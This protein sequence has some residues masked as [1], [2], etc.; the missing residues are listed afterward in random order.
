M[1]FQTIKPL[2]NESIIEM[3]SAIFLLALIFMLI[4]IKIAAQTGWCGITPPTHS[5]YMASIQ[6]QSVASTISVSR[7]LAIHFYVVRNSL[8]TLPGN[9]SAPS[10]Q[11]TLITFIRNSIEIANVLFQPKMISFYPSAITFINSDNWFS[12]DLSE[13]S[14]I[15]SSYNDPNAINVYLVQDFIPRS[16]NLAGY[17]QFPDANPSNALFL[18]VS[19]AGKYTM[20]H[21]LGHYFNILHTFN[22]TWFDRPVEYPAAY[23]GNCSTSG[24]MICDTPVEPTCGGTAWSCSNSDICTSNPV[25]VTYQGNIYTFTPIRGNV[26]SY[27]NCSTQSFTSQQL[28]RIENTLL[29]HPNR[30]FLVDNNNPPAIKLTSM[31]AYTIRTNEINQSVSYLKQ[32]PLKLFRDNILINTVYS[33]ATGGIDV[34]AGNFIPG[35]QLGKI[36]PEPN[37][38]LNGNGAINS[39]DL[40]ILQNH[41]TNNV[42]ITTPYRL[43]AA[44][45]NN[46]G[47]VSTF[48]AIFLQ[49]IILGIYTTSL[50]NNTSWRYIPSYAISNTGFFTQLNQNPFNAQWSVNNEIRGY[51]VNPALGITKT[52]FDD[53][54]ISLQNNPLIDQQNTWSFQA[55]KVGDLDFSV[56]E[57]PSFRTPNEPQLRG[58][59]PYTITY[60]EKECLEKGQLYEIEL[61]ANCKD[62]L[63]VYQIGAKIDLKQIEVIRAEQTEIGKFDEDNYNMSAL[64]DGQLKIVWTDVDKG[65]KV[66]FNKNR[67]LFKIVVMPKIQ[68]C[69]LTNAIKIDKEVM[70]TMFLSERVKEIP[71]EL[72]WKVNKTNKLISQ[73]SSIVAP[74]PNPTTNEVTFDV[75]LD[76]GSLL[77]RIILSDITGRKNE[78]VQ[79]GFKGFNRFVIKSLDEFKPGLINYQIIVDNMQQLF[80][81]SFIKF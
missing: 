74:F 56:T 36:I 6:T 72:E 28:D 58:G 16:N 46:S 22:E 31:N 49:K 44:D 34:D 29:T 70:P 65:E 5:A 73:V 67:S 80:S 35:Y 60:N 59:D 21:E 17:A 75:N 26:M 54:D 76:R 50:P 48:D 81:G 9:N 7:P 12:F 57:Y 43:I 1:D 66:K 3:Q 27:N 15:N 8:G 69:D 55:I 20:S 41:N 4:N 68:I 14:N 11:N 51:L 24:D 30:L 61:E 79:E 71:T 37:L 62:D 38:S 40:A 23:G 10:S 19:R 45:L 13:I 52:F 77:V 47:N 53:F 64:K 78:F 63:L 25:T 2:N 18:S 32:I 42:P 33:A 39:A